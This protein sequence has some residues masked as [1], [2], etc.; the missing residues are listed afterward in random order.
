MQR[1]VSSKTE[2][3]HCALRITETA[4]YEF[5]FRRGAADKEIDRRMFRIQ[6]GNVVFGYAVLK[7]NGNPRRTQEPFSRTRG[8]QRRVRRRAKDMGADLCR[9]Q[10]IIKC[11][12]QRAFFQNPARPFDLFPA[13]GVFV[14]D[15]ICLS[16]R[17]PLPHI[18]E[19]RPCV[20]AGIA[21]P[22]RKK[23]Y[24]RKVLPKEKHAAYRF[25]RGVKQKT[26]AHCRTAALIQGE[27]LPWDFL[28]Y[29]RPVRDYPAPPP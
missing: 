10:E 2:I 23:P 15:I 22:L 20:V 28:S 4:F 25:Y 29:R 27:L 12:A 13:Y 16:F 17:M 6:R 8:K 5:I 14:K 19:K 7:E 3:P 21:A 24:I 11:M 1:I 18:T 26:D 9:R